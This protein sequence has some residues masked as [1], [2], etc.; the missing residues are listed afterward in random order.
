MKNLEG[1]VVIVT[2]ATSGIGEMAALQIASAGASVVIAARRE[3][4][5]QK[6]VE[7]IKNNGGEALFIRTDVTRQADIVAL[8][9]STI[10]KFGQLDCAVNNAGATGATLTPMAEIEEAD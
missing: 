3:D 10:D 4:K 9:N 5:G 7:D 6:V 1:K 8:I 2:G